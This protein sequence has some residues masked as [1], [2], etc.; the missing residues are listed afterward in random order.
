MLCTR[1]V[2][3]IFLGLA[4]KKY[5]IITWLPFFI[6]CTF[7]CK[8]RNDYQNKQDLGKAQNLK[9]E[10]KTIDSVSQ[11]LSKKIPKGWSCKTIDNK[12]IIKFNKKVTKINLTS[13]PVME[14]EAD[15]KQ[16]EYEDDCIVELKFEKKITN[17]EYTKLVN[18]R[19]KLLL[20]L[21]NNK[22]IGGKDKYGKMLSGRT[23]A[24][25]AG[26]RSSGTRRAGSR[27]CWR[28]GCRA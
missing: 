20:D 22:N 15:R 1:E 9:F 23:A 6:L 3:F 13:L 17:E 10:K 16:F 8:S 12:I 19:E 21:K 27:S 4:M 7:G 28:S 26:C 24:A 14:S 25:R 5:F 18:N 11:V 2:D